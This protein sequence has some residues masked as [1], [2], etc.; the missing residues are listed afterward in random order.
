MGKLTGGT[1]NISEVTNA[2]LPFTKEEYWTWNIAST[3]EAVEEEKHSIGRLS[4]GS[5][6]QNGGMEQNEGLC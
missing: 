3:N 1:P 4:E 6:E 5:E 2:P